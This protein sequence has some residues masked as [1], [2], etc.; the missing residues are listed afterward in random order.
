[1]TWHG[2]KSCFLMASPNGIDI[3]W[4]SEYQTP[5]SLLDMSQIEKLA[6]MV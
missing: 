4:A 3:C 1:M 6:P 2:D 5:T